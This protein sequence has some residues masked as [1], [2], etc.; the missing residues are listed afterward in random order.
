MA[1]DRSAMNDYLNS[2]DRGIA[3]GITASSNISHSNSGRKYFVVDFLWRPTVKKN[4][5]AYWWH[6]LYTRLEMFLS[7]QGVES[8]IRT[9][10]SF[11]SVLRTR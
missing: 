9:L 5:P 6:A 1:G 4:F 10:L 7:V 2:F 3:N 11:G 8:Q